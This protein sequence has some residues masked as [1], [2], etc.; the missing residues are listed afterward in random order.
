MTES[1]DHTAGVYDEEFTHTSIGKAQRE[2]VHFYVSNCVDL[3]D[4]RVLEVNC[5]TGEDAKWMSDQGAEVTATDISQEMISI[6]REKNPGITALVCDMRQI[7]DQFK[8]E[9]FDVIFSN[10]G[11]MNCLN[12]NDLTETIGGLSALLKPG[13]KM[14]LVV[15]PR[16][17]TWEFN[18]FVLK[19]QFK[20]AL[21]RRKREG[22]KAH[23]DGQWVHTW[24]YSPRNLRKMVP[25]KHKMTRPVGYFIP[26]SYL[27]PFFKKR[28][29][30]L[31]FL[32]WKERTFHRFPF[33]PA[34]SDHYFSY[35]EK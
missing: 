6:T 12:P 4:K 7:S 22:V 3:Q 13:G 10:F 20:K 27:E 2:R 21:R 17:C 24:Y 32:I 35:F 31:R 11:G 8:G 33:L 1:F 26:P 30:F 14:F 15:M 23:V 16:F 19:G 25:L 28:P 9:Q 5:G 18:Y 29:K 34:R